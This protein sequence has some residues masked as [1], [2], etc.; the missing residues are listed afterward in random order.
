MTPTT[1]ALS[2]HKTELGSHG[3]YGF[4]RN[5]L[6][7]TKYCFWILYRPVTHQDIRVGGTASNISGWT[8]IAP[9][10]Y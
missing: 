10:Y 2:S 6:A 3:V 4:G 1:A 5:F 9:H 8:E 7:N